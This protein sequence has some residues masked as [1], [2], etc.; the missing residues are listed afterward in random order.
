MTP[1]DSEQH[2]H[3]IAA[4]TT[5]RV[6]GMSETERAD[7]A[8]KL[9]GR[10]DVVS[11]PPYKRSGAKA[12][13]AEAARAEEAARVEAEL[14]RTERRLWRLERTSTK[15][16]YQMSTGGPPS[17]RY[18]RLISRADRLERKLNRLR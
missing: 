12:A 11:D 13:A 7:V 9:A 10:R 5:K 3:D 14:H 18:A 4:R 1:P 6:G 2:P 15:S 16:R 17:G 8:R